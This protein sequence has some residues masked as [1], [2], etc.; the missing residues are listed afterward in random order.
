MKNEMIKK[1]ESAKNYLK[2]WKA[3]TNDQITKNHIASVFNTLCN[4]ENLANG[5]STGDGQLTQPAVSSSFCN[6]STLKDELHYSYGV[7]VCFKCN[8]VVQLQND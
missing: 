6:C 4:I 1:I 3:D 8:K 5:L 2:R 7:P